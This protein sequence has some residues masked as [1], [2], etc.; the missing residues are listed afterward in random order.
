MGSSFSMDAAD[1]AISIACKNNSQLIAL[2][3]LFCEL[4]YAYSCHILGFVTPT[5]MNS[6]IE[7]ART[8]ANQWFEILE[9]IIS[10][11]DSSRKYFLK[12]DFLV[13]DTSIIHAILNYAED[14]GIKPT[15]VGTQGRSGL[16]KMVL[17]SIASA[18]LLILYAL[19]W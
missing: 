14:H 6:N 3:V 7:D 10:K 15:V 18:V 1:Y 16:K 5:T 4:K 2:Y 9:N 13:T 8:K 11:K 17:G 19:Y 12:A